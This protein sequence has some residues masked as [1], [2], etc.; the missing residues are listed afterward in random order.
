LPT[1]PVS[2]CRITSDAGSVGNGQVSKRPKK[3]AKRSLPKPLPASASAENRSGEAVTVAWTLSF[4]ATAGSDILALVLWLLGRLWP[5]AA[6]EQAG[7]WLMLPL[8]ALFVA[9][10]SGLVC[11]VLTP[12]VYRLRQVPPPRA[13][14][15]FALVVSGIPLGTTLSLFIRN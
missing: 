8:L 3:P 5:G 2:V 7:P 12:I 1:L 15:V 10:V 6:V 13:V 9:A 4:L 14:T 11:L